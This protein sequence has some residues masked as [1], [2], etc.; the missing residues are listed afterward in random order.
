VR[1]TLLTITLA[2]TLAGTAQAQTVTFTPNDR[3]THSQVITRMGE[4][5]LHYWRM[6]GITGCPDGLAIAPMETPDDLFPSRG[7]GCGVL[8]VE[9]HVEWVMDY[10]RSVVNDTR[11]RE[12][13]WSIREVCRLVVHETGHALGL[14]HTD[15]NRFSVM[16]QYAEPHIPTC[17]RLARELVPNP[18]L[19]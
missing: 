11:R 4:A 19:R 5:A 1:T 12:Q 16:G 9:E 3:A 17:G 14:E 8:I 13:R 2:L 15:R 6:N 7:G 10:R 18:A